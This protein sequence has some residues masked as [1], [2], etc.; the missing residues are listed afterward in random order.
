M[1][2]TRFSRNFRA[3]LF[4]NRVTLCLILV[5][6]VGDRH[7]LAVLLRYR[8]AYFSGHLPFNLILNSLALLLGVILCDLLVV[9]SALI[10]VFCVAVLFGNMIALFSGDILAPC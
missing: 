3:L 7:F 9:G 6:S 10:F 4:C 8:M 1:I 2:I 5:L